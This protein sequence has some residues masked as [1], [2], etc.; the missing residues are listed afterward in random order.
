MADPN[1]NAS[2]FSV[3]ADV[4][5]TITVN[6]SAGFAVGADVLVHVTSYPA[7]P[8]AV[9]V[10]G[11]TATLV[12]NA[13]DATIWEAKN[14]TG[15]GTAVDLTSG[16]TS[17]SYLSGVIEE[18]APG[19]LD[20]LVSSTT[21]TTHG[22]NPAVLVSNASPLIGDQCFGLSGRGYDLTSSIA[23]WSLIWNQPQGLGFEPGHVMYREASADGV[24]TADFYNANTQTTGLCLVVYRHSSV[25]PS[26]FNPLTGRGGAA[27]QPLA[28]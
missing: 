2:P 3:A 21:D 9:T 11:V 19:T 28:A 1:V 13:F 16:D 25:T 23:P 10:D 15:G 12:G 20:T 24:V 4:S 27:A 6:A 17:G 22:F 8:T 5:V 26:V 7:N 14:V 18:L